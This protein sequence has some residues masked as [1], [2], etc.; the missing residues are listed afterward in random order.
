MQNLRTRKSISPN[1]RISVLER[2][3]LLM[4]KKSVLDNIHETN[5]LMHKN[6]KTAERLAGIAEEVVII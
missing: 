3:A 2:Q 6:T 4:R 5:K 1:R